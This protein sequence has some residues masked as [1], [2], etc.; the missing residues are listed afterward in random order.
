LLLSLAGLDKLARL[1]AR[2]FDE[3]EFLAPHGL[4]ALSAWHKEH[5]YTID[6]E[7]FRASIDYEPAESTTALFGGNSNWRGPIW[8]P[9]KLPGDQRA[10]AIPQILRRRSVDRVPNGLWAAPDARRDRGGPVRQA[11]FPFLSRCRR[12]TAMF[13]RN[14]NPAIRSGLAR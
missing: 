10:R 7:G 2:L 14:G 5:P 8:F 11:H 6:V 4:R 13:R 12:K 9:V 3:S 1:L